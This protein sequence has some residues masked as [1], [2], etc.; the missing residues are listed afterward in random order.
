MLLMK[1]CAFNC[2]LPPQGSAPAH[3]FQSEERALGALVCKQHKVSRRE[4]TDVPDRQPA[5]GSP[6][7][8]PHRGLTEEWCYCGFFK[9]RPCLK[10]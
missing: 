6:A 7:A 4:C 5:V 9:M 2:C 1:C 8:H 3:A 10:S